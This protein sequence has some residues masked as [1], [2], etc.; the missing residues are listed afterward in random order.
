MALRARLIDLISSLNFGENRVEIH[1]A[2]S[3]ARIAREIH[4]ES[5]SQWESISCDNG[6]NGTL[7]VTAGKTIAARRVIPMTQRVRFVLETRWEHA[8]KPAFG[9]VWSAPTRKGHVDHSSLKKQH[10][11]AFA[12]ANKET[13]GTQKLPAWVLYAFRH[14]FLTR[15]GESG[16]DAWTLA[17]IAGHSSIA[18]SSRYVHPSEDVV[19]NAMERMSGHNIILRVCSPRRFHCKL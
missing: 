7:L 2:L 14:T 12:N 10:A 9:W 3:R 8:Q 1:L 15:L 11:R 17:R 5:T 18:I 19:L 16:C 13:K 4:R 6:R